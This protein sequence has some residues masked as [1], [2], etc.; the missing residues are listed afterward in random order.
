MLKIEK[1]SYTEDVYDIIGVEGNENFYANDIL[2]HNCEISLDLNGG[3]CNLTSINVDD[4]ESQADLNQRVRDAV[5]I[6]TL[7]AGYTDFHYLGHQWKEIAERDSLLGV[8]MTGIGS[9]KILSLDILQAGE[10]AKQENIRVAKLINI[11]PAKRIGTIKPE[12]TASLVLKCASGIHAWHNDYYVRR[13]RINKDEAIY[14]Y[15][16]DKLGSEFLEDDCFNPKRTSV[17]SVPIKAPEGSIVRTETPEELL[18]R[19]KRFQIEWIRSTHIEGKNTHNVSVTVSVKP[20]EW[21]R[22]TTWMWN[23]KDYYNGISLLDFNGGT[24]PQMPF[25]DI[26]KEQYEELNAKLAEK[27][28]SF[29]ITDVKEEEDFT[30]LKGESACAGGACE[31]SSI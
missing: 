20:D 6:G 17:L 5:F 15:L 31:V 23:N 25:E 12:G 22:V 28:K 21:D 29:E 2:V 16:N 10:I 4:V 19:V 8:S 30:D 3:F 11:N 13:M 1:L 18:E 9:G 26:T 14:S 7:Q 27:I 24:Y